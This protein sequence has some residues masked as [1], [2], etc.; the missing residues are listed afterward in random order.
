M[1]VLSEGFPLSGERVIHR[2]V[3]KAALCRGGV[4]FRSSPPFT[5]LCLLPDCPRAT[6][7]YWPS[8]RQGVLATC[9]L[10][11]TVP[12]PLQLPWAAPVGKLPYWSLP[13]TSLPGAPSFLCLCLMT[14]DPQDHNLFCL[15]CRL[16]WNGQVFFS[17]LSDCE[18]GHQCV[19]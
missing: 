18:L 14:L 13:A 5:V 7:S 10:P 8:S 4:A 11:G 19:V 12:L 2:T 9:L 3:R 1:K 15:K 16:K 17:F 6:Q